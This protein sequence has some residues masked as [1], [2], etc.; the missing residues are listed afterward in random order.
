MSEQKL[1]YDR[2]MLCRQNMYCIRGKV[3]ALLS[4]EIFSPS[5]MVT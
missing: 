3:M 5:K 2:F 4:R 1:C